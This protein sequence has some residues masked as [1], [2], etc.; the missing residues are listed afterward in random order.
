MYR[1]IVISNTNVTLIRKYFTPVYREKVMNEGIPSMTCTVYK[2]LLEQLL[3][4]MFL[5]NKGSRVEKAHEMEHLAYIGMRHLSN[6]S[7]S[8]KFVQKIK[9]PWHQHLHLYFLLSKPL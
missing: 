6:V 5:E 2:A 9:Q 7:K 8:R 1:V 3:L 4:S